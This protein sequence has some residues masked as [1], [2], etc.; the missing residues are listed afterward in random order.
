MTTTEKSTTERSSAS[1]RDEACPL[2]AR[3]N[4]SG[5]ALGSAAP[6]AWMFWMLRLAGIYNLVWGTLVILFPNQ[7]FTLAG[8]EIP[9]YPQLWQCIGMI[10]GVYGIGYWIAASDPARHWPIVFVGFLGKVFGPIGFVFGALQGT[11]PWVAGTVNIT[12]DLIWLPGFM[13]ALYYAAKVNSGDKYAAPAYTWDEALHGVRFA[14][15]KTLEEMSSKQDL[16]LLFVRHAGCTFCREMLA[17]LGE[18]RQAIEDRGVG[19]A[20]VHVSTERSIAGLLDRYGL[21]ST[22][23]LS[24]PDRRLF[25][26]FELKRGAFWQLLG[27]KIWWRGFKAAIVSGHWFG[28]MEGDGFQMPGVFL[29]RDGRIIASFRHELA[30]DRPDYMKIVLSAQR[31]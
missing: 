7:W 24:D 29:I 6:P 5:P 23:Q 19:T 20:V 9:N 15:G 25:R 14:S 21:K 31:M 2:P 8:M 16:L 4:I 17:D 1:D 22:D 3:S 30:S 28:T 13:L 18:Q 10:V 26:T 11:W 12:N 27:P